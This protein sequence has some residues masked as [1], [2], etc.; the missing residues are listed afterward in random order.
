MKIIGITG[1][2]AC[3]KSTVTQLFAERGARTRS[4]DAD[5]RTVL[6]PGETTL[7]AVR[8][9]FP[10]ATLPDGTL[11]RARLAA[12]IFADADARRRL[13]AITHPAIL[14]RMRAAIEAAR[15]SSDD[16][17]LV[18]ET[19]LLYEAALEPLFDAVIAV[20]ASPGVQAARLQA[21]EAAAGRPALTAD[22]IAGRLD[23]QLSNEEKARRADFVVRTDGRLAETE[24]QVECI[25][26]ELSRA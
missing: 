23:A 12:T 10:D 8:A 26:V 19:P 13:E 20:V 17:L 22:A 7:A 5:A 6:Q 24:A 11:D 2:I 16:G 1:G 9:A 21:R 18:Y 3:G 4:A 15:A 14:A 25:W